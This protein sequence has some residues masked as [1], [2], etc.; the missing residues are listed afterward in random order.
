MSRRADEQTRQD[1]I[2]SSARLLVCCIFMLVCSSA[3]PLVC[4]AEP[5][6]ALVM[7]GQPKYPH[8]FQH[9]DYVNPNAPQGGSATFGEVGTFDNMLPWLIKGRPAAGLDFVNDHLMQR[10][11][12]EP[13]TMYGLIAETVELADDRSWIAFAINPAA[14]FQDDTPIMAADVA[15]SFNI[16]KQHGRP[17]TRRM[18]GN[19]ARVEITAPR[20]IVFHLKRDADPETPMILALLQVLPQH[21]WQQHDPTVTSLAPPIGSGPYKIIKVEAG[22]SITYEKVKNYWAQNLPSVKGLYNFKTVRYDYYRDDGVALQAFKSGAFDFRRELNPKRWASD[23]TVKDNKNLKR[24]QLTDG[25]P[26]PL[27]AFVFNTRRDLF[28]DIRVRQALTLAFDFE[29]LNKQL[30]NGAYARTTSI[31]PKSALAAHDWIAPTTDASGLAGQR[32]NLR[33][34]QDLLQQ[35]GWQITD[36]QLVDA[37][38]KRFAFE[39]LLNNPA[40]EK[41][42]LYFMRTLTRLGITAKIRTVDSAQYLGRMAQFDYDMTLV[43]WISTLSPGSEQLVYWGSAAAQQPGSRNY[44]GVADAKIDA[45]ARSLNTARD[46]PELVARAQE[47]DSRIMQGVYFIPLYHLPY[48]MIAW[49]QNK[50]TRPEIVPLYGAVLESWWANKID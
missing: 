29:W 50:I 18:F 2:Y 35:A 30:F 17:N 26:A 34:A 43:T 6:H 3:R 7:H 5:Q 39:I 16:M 1:W 15:Y 37:H 42:A 28:A 4:Y 46:Q 12:D 10:S 27:T 40:D 25:K 20:R 32:N 38:N 9:F 48:D 49:W 36:N 44:A 24:A 8:N 11:W 19:V 23:Y 33:R 41:V 22:R 47:L 31:F 13:F 14:R 21:Y 45:L